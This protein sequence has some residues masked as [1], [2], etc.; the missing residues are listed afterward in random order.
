MKSKSALVLIMV[1]CLSL[2]SPLPVSAEESYTIT[3]VQ[4]KALSE[5]LTTLKEL[6]LSLRQKLDNYKI[7]LQLTAQELQAS[8]LQLLKAENESKTFILTLKKQEIRLQEQSSSLIIVN[9]SLKKLR[10]KEKIKNIFFT[11]IVGYLV[12]KK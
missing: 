3:K 2:F 1:L 12:I 10:Q 11:A 6:V 4:I 9:K 7:Q 5:N 8:Q